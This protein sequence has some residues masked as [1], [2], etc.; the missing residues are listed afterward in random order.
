MFMR[1]VRFLCAVWLILPIPAW[2]QDMPAGQPKM[3]CAVYGLKALEEVWIGNFH[4]YCQPYVSTGVRSVQ[5]LAPVAY[6]PSA[7]GCVVFHLNAIV[8]ISYS[9]LMETG[10]VAMAFITPSNFAIYVLP[11]KNGCTD[12]I[13]LG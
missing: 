10:Q 6:G 11:S 7:D 1:V 5:V 2:A 4:E 13:P 12:E 9:Y 8:P 3:V